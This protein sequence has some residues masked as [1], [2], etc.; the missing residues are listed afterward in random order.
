MISNR[1][2][3][4]PLL[5]CLVLLMALCHAT[6]ADRVVVYTQSVQP[7]STTLMPVLIECD[8]DYAAFQ[9]DFL[10][11]EGITVPAD[12]Y[13]NP[14]VT[15]VKEMGNGHVV[16]TG[17][18]DNQG[19]RVASY[20]MPT[21]LFKAKSGTL[22]NL[23]L[24]VAPDFQGGVVSLTNIRFTTAKSKETE[25]DDVDVTLVTVLLGDANGDGYVTIADVTAIINRIN[26]AVTG[27][28][29]EAAADV[30]GDGVI[31]IADVTGVINI[32]NQ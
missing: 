11:P 6:G 10:L 17:F 23:P 13:G 14:Q 27:T 32:I 24:C 26:N 5:T 15:L 31:S 8:N 4:R 18:L 22:L 1:G 30:N 25:F 20:A 7:G 2:L 29:V 21:A 12:A 28:F 19:V 16:T 9:M 3:H